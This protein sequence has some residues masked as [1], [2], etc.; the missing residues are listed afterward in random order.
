M[1]C[2][3]SD[4]WRLPSENKERKRTTESAAV[5]GKVRE[6]DVKKDKS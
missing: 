5:F 3:E 6:S 4:M 1:G 2:I